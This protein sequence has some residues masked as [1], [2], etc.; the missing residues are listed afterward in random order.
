M[1]GLPP[2]LVSRIHAVS[3]ARTVPKGLDAMPCEDVGI[4]GIGGKGIP[5]GANGMP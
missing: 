2:L 1:L 3:H 5:G 4:G